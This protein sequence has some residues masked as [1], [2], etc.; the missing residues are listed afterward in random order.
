MKDEQIGADALAFAK[1][2]AKAERSLQ[3]KK[4][5]RFIFYRRTIDEHSIEVFRYELPVELVSR[6]SWVIQWRR[7]SLI[8]KYPR[9]RVYNTFS[10][11]YLRDGKDLGFNDDLKRLVALKSKVTL[12]ERNVAE[13]IGSKKFDLF[14][15]EKE[16]IQ[17]QKILERVKRAKQNILEAER[18]LSDKV[19]QYQSK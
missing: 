14:F 19:K 12:Q 1:A 7:A 11:F 17:L 13:Y 5:V 15:N 9:G 4:Y 10:T 8:C 16:D 6:W 2:M 3:L 18:R